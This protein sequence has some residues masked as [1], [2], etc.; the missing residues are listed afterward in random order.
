MT[1]YNNQRLDTHVRVGEEIAVMQAGKRCG[2]EW[3]P[4][5]GDW[6]VSH[7]PRN[8][9][10]H[11]E[12]P[13]DH[14]VDLAIKILRDPLTAKVRPEARELALRLQAYDFYSESRTQLTDADLVER[15]GDERIDAGEA[16]AVSREQ[17]TEE[18]L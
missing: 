12:G 7:S 11:A 16:S 14:W 10:S 9:N 1:R 6:F 5:M 4:W 15:F 13:W 17:D 2:I 3:C 8:D 18:A